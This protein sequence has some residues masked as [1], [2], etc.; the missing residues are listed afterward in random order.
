MR[1]HQEDLVDD[2]V[3]AQRNPV[4][5]FLDHQLCKTH[6]A[7]LTRRHGETFIRKVLFTLSELPNFPPAQLIWN[8]LHTDV[9]LYC[10]FRIKRE[11]VFRI[12]ELRDSK[13]GVLVSVEHGSSK[14]AAAIREQIR[15][16]S[17]GDSDWEIAG[18]IRQA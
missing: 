15:M 11:P 3:D 6:A 1:M 9:P 5:A 14:K 16:K 7:R 8:A 18:R 12:L 17:N 4:V 13:D 10:F 2:M